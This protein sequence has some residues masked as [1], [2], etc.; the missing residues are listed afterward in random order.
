VGKH[1]NKRRQHKLIA[2]KAYHDTDADI[3]NW[4]ESIV[5]GERSEALRDLIRAFIGKPSRPR[6][7]LTIPELL[8]V[9]QDTLWIRDALND[10]PAYLERLVQY[11]AATTAAQGVLQPQAGTPSNGSRPPA[12]ELALSDSDSERRARRMRR[13][14]W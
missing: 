6:K 13:A 9:R 12:T 2:F 1:K 5:E 7:L 11:V 8:E 10:M 4:W 14:S 3:L